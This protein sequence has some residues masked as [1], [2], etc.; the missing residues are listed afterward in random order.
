MIAIVQQMSWRCGRYTVQ[1]TM[2][3][4]NPAWARYL[5]IRNGKVV[6]ASFSVPDADWC[7]SIERITKLGRYVEKLSDPKRYTYRLGRPTKAE[8]ARRAAELLTE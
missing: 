6:G 7:E 5:I 2:R 8:Q 1:Q 4:D 3:Q